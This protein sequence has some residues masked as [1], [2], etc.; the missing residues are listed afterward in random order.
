MK[1]GFFES[2]TLLLI[3]S[4]INVVWF[5]ANFMFIGDLLNPYI[6]I[7][8]FI[9][10]R[11]GSRK[12]LI[13][14]ASVLAIV[15]LSGYLS[16]SSHKIFKSD[17][18]SFILTL[19]FFSQLAG[20]IRDEK[21]KDVEKLT[22]EQEKQRGALRKYMDENTVL[23]IT[24][25]ELTRKLMTRFQ[26]L[27]SAFEVSQKFNTL[28]EEKVFATVI[29][30]LSE[31]VGIKKAGVYSLDNH[32]MQLKTSLGKASELITFKRS[33]FD[34]KMV[35]EAVKS[36]RIVT[37]IEN[38]SSAAAL[39]DASSGNSHLVVAP[40]KYFDEIYGVIVVDELPVESFND[41]SVRMIDLIAGWAGQSFSKIKK[42]KEIENETPFDHLTNSYKSNHIKTIM[43]HEF[44][45]AI[46]YKFHLS[47][48][49]IEIKNFSDISPK[50]NKNLYATISFIVKSAIRDID[51]YG[52]CV[53]NG[54]MILI[55]PATSI[56]GS[57]ILLN[58]LNEKIG[59]LDLAPYKQN[60]NN[61]E[62]SWESYSLLDNI[63]KPGTIENLPF[64]SISFA[65][66]KVYQFVL[67]RLN[68]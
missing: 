21:T 16:G 12:N 28:D 31:H 38:A 19:F 2:L 23:S 11:H 33:S 17:T 10:A 54:V 5:P 29:D 39:E 60:D 49:K 8:V 59:L 48:C 13:T 63:S 42:F 3:A 40:I 43:K 9:A 26:S 20:H 58:R 62:I 46:R 35:A 1:F 53:K 44:S 50:I 64:E 66:E 55:L 56:A 37:V 61:L 52:M 41:T 34:D 7:S 51:I 30:V 57:R 67:S 4:F 27:T 15:F 45:K 68:I 36:G 6:V 47:V 14:I 18:L 24:N 22:A 32:I 65:S 25:R